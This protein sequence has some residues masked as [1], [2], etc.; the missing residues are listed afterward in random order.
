MILCR[1]DADKLVQILKVN[2]PVRTGNLRDNGIQSVQPLAKGYLVQIGYPST[3]LGTPATEDYA[4]F[5]EI[6]NKSSKGWVMRCCQ[7]WKQMMETE[8]N[9]RNEGSVDWDGL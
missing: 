3:E 9:L 2:A 1:L 5:T 6:K 4:L 7:E 8:L